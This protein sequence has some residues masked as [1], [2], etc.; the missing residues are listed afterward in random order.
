MNA[1]IQMAGQWGNRFIEHASLMM[2]QAG[3]LISVLFVLDRLLS[4][5]VRA[6]VRYGIWMLVLVKLVLSPHFS[7][8][9]GVGNWI[10]WQ[11]AVGENGP[12]Q[13]NGETSTTVQGT[14]ALSA[15]VPSASS[16][17]MLQKQGRLTPAATERPP[18]ALAEEAGIR[19]TWQGTALIVWLLG[20]ATLSLG[21]VLR[22][23][24]VRR[25]IRSSEHPDDRLLL[26][27]ADAL[28]DMNIRIR[29]DLRLTQG[30]P[31]PAVCRLWRPVIL[32]PEVLVDR[33]PEDNLRA[34]LIHELCHIK[35]ADPWVNWAQT[36]VQVFYFYNPLVWLANTC[37]RRVREQA[38]DEG[39]LVCLKGRLHC[40]SHTLIDIAEMV[41]LKPKLS[42]GL[43]G[44]AESKTQL[45]ERINLMLNKPIPKHAHLGLFGLALIIALGTLLLP[46]AA[47]QTDPVSTKSGLFQPVTGQ[48]RAD[49]LKE[50]QTILES[51]L[52]VYEAGDI[53]GI[54]S[55]FTVDTIA[56]PAEHEALIGKGA[57][58]KA[59][60][61]DREKGAKVLDIKGGDQRY[62]ICGDLIYTVGC[63]ALSVAVPGMPG[64][65][66]DFRN[67]LTIWQRQADGS[68]KVKLDA[69]N[70]A[71]VPDSPLDFGGDT[72]HS[73][74]VTWQ[75]SAPSNS[76]LS[77]ADGHMIRQLEDRFH[78]HFPA[79]ELEK[80]MT[81]YAEDATMLV[82]GR[83][84]VQGR[85]AIRELI[86]E[87]VA[88]S[89]PLV[90]LNRDVIQIEGDANMIYVVHL[91][92]W[93]MKNPSSGNEF[94][95]PG[96][97]VH[98]WQRQPDDSWKIFIDINN[99]DVPV[100]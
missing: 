63:H 89:P 10:H 46:M 2:I 29:I 53:S 54:L 12:S 27:L 47:A 44:V 95:I 93:T 35:R 68:L 18:V 73:G 39:V 84:M 7:L 87:G 92:A 69:Y 50:M 4:R 19:L 26:I 83:S 49:L 61:K 13:V 80:A 15:S 43:V 65:I 70:T 88:A 45:N 56:L 64:M 74:T 81:Y 62:W 36:L 11:A 34:V 76:G 32:L 59:Q 20:M 67:G 31:S 28:K 3:V 16:I 79:Q 66:T 21:L 33:L 57:L 25:I 96:K 90:S 100:S 52:S 6:S 9:V 82:M 71:Q 37:I 94:T 38:V 85:D 86:Q 97:G 22:A 14:P 40:Y 72:A 42:M 99:T 60:V 77:Q 17:E 24:C 55:H 98:V 8:P 91:F 30:V 51:M 5:R 78:A 41:T 75:C 23:L 48:A 1:L 58:H